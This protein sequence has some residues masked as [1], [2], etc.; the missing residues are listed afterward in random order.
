MRYPGAIWRPPA[1]AAAHKFG[2]SQYGWG[3]RG[4]KRGVVLHSADG[5]WP[6][7][8]SVLDDPNRGSWHFTVGYDRV[9]QHFDADIHCWHGGDTD[10]DG[11]VK[12]NLDLGGIEV[13]GRE[14]ELMT[15]YQLDQVVKL[16]EWWA[17]QFGLTKFGRYPVQA[18]VWT[19]AE[20]N[21]VS[22]TYT[23]CPANR[24][25]TT[26][27]ELLRR[28]NEGDEMTDQDFQKIEAMIRASEVRQNQYTNEQMQ[29]L[30][31]FLKAVAKNLDD[32]H[33]RIEAKLP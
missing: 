1:P 27:P 5:Y 31:S 7:L 23:R 17:A 20:H 25:D 33:T 18:N 28:L 30:L 29:Q 21:E 4:R 12:A 2:Y 9:E 16:N 26:W 24:W 13:L 19:M 10:D 8:H 32:D 3:V 14:G 15:P 6:G 22:N 11:G